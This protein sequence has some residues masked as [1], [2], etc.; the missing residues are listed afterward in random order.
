MAAIVPFVIELPA[1]LPKIKGSDVHLQ[2]QFS[3]ADG[4]MSLDSKRIAGEDDREFILKYFKDV[5]KRP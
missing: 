3:T 5:C 4:D 1:P 2:L